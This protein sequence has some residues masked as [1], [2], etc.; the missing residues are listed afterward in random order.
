MNENQNTEQKSTKIDWEPVSQATKRWAIMSQWSTDLDN[1]QNSWI[2]DVEEANDGT[3]DAIV[4][5]PDELIMLKGWKDGT[6]LNMEVE[7]TPKGNVIVV[8]EIKE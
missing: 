4:T 8:T 5:F 7:Q 1:Y 6:K 3:G 2:C